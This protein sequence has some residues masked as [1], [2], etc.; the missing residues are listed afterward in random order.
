M[1][2]AKP[3]DDVMKPDGR[4]EQTGSPPGEANHTGE[5]LPGEVL[6]SKVGPETVNSA[7]EQTTHDAKPPQRVRPERTIKE[8]P[9]DHSHMITWRSRQR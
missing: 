7:A 3:V 5:E 2:G 8:R 6:W 9:R 1:C 4:Q